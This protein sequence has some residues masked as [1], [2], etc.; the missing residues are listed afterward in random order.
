MVEIQTFDSYTGSDS[1]V[2]M[3]TR[4]DSRVLSLSLSSSKLFHTQNELFYECVYI[5]RE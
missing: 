3:L 1:P 2:V 4:E 5:E